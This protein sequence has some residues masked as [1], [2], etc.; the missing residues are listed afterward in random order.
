VAVLTGHVLK[1]PSAISASSPV[2]IA[3]DLDSLEA[4]IEH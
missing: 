1:D 4:A 3:P 2:E